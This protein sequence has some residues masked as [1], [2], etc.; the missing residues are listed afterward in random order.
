MTSL[1][2]SSSISINNHVKDAAKGSLGQYTYVINDT[3]LRHLELIWYEWEK[4]HW[5]QAVHFH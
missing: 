4:W 3:S 2:S 5:C 1:P